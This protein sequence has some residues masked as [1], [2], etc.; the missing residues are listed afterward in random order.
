MLVQFTF[1]NFKLFRDETLL[2]LLPAPINEHKASLLTDPVD[3]E[4]VLPV[5]GIYGPNGSGKST[6]LKALASLAGWVTGG[7]VRGSGP[8]FYLPDEGYGELPTGFD[9]LFRNGG[10]LFRYQLQLLE[11]TIIEE[12]LFYGKLGSDD[13]G[14]LFSRRDMEVHLGREAGQKALERLSP[15]R[16]L[17]SLFDSPSDTEAVR[18]A[19]RWFKEINA[20]FGEDFSHNLPA[21]NETREQLCLMLQRMGLD[22]WDYDPSSDGSLLLIHG[23][24]GFGSHTYSLPFKEESAGTRKLLSFLPRMLRCLK[25]GSVLLADDLDRCLHPHMIRFLVEQF[26]NRENNPHGAQLI[27]TSHNTALLTPAAL[28]RDEI[29]LC[30]RPAGREAALYPLSSYKKENGLI[31]RNDEAYGKQYLEGRYGAL[32][33]VIRDSSGSEA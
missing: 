5:V 19:L 28:R 8:L 27:F 14:I 4:R 24:R 1:N 16:P 6:V 31:P 3:Q 7:S 17:L 26:T 25:E 13:A 15:D 11:H 30:C 20:D 33:A 10:Y 12:T 9:V 2:D 32:P 21:D 22:I 23:S 18:A 29:W